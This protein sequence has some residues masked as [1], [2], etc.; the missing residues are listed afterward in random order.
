VATFSDP[1]GAE[2]VGDYS[3]D[4]NWGDGTTASTGTISLSGGVFTV[5]GAHT[6]AEESA[7]DHSGSNPY[8]IMVT[9]HHE[10]SAP[11]TVTSTATVSDPAVTATGGQTIS[12]TEGTST[13]SVVVATFTDPGGYETDADY[14]ATINWGDNSTSTGTIANGTVT[15]S[16]TYT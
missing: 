16:H 7:D 14:S 12:A 15:G 10:S 11:Q 9:I 2:E 3:T 6:Y 4:I 8:T 1:G 5:S 13:G